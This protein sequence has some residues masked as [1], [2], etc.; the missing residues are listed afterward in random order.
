[1]QIAQTRI[2]PTTTVRMEAQIG[3]LPETVA[4][5]VIAD[6]TTTETMSLMDRTALLKP[7][8]IPTTI[9]A[10]AIATTMA[11]TEVEDKVFTA[12]PFLATVVGDEA[13]VGIEV[14]T[15]IGGTDETIIRSNIRFE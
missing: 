6:E 10:T 5:S 15:T 13:T 4:M 3:T 1:M 14:A 9:I 11:T 7:A 8:W 12:I 2:G